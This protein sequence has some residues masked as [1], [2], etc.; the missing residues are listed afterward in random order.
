MRLYLMTTACLITAM[1]A[2]T[3]APPVHADDT[4]TYEV[5]TT[6]EIPVANIE[7]NDVSGLHAL[8]KVPLP[9]R[10]NATVGNPRSNDAEVRSDWRWLAKPSTWVTVR[11]YYRGSLLCEETLDIGVATCYGS[12]TFKS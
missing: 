12:A 2:V 3:T 4:V 8:Q 10:M 11:V 1:A 7:Y 9:W 6:S 5:I